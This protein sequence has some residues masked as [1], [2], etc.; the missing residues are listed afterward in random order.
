MLMDHHVQPGG[1]DMPLLRSWRIFFAR[2]YRYVAP[3]ELFASGGVLF[4]DSHSAQNFEIEFFCLPSFGFRVSDFEFF[5]PELF[6][7]TGNGLAD[8]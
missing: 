1:S 4:F 8:R 7:T 5:S 2:L 6:T 3:P